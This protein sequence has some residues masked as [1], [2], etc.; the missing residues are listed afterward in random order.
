MCIHKLS[1]QDECFICFLSQTAKDG[2]KNEIHTKKQTIQLKKNGQRPEQTFFQRRHTDGQQ[3]RKRRSTSLIIR[4]MQI[5][6]TKR[7]H[8]T[9]VGM[10]SIRKMRYN[11]YQRGRVE[12]GTLLH[13][14][15][16][17]KLVQPLWKTV[18]KFFKNLKIGL[19]H[20]PAILFLGI[21][22]KK[23]KTLTQKDTCIPKLTEILLIITKIWKQL[24]CPSIYN[25]DTHTHTHIT[26]YYSAIKKKKQ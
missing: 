20:N 23:T 12:N 1:T 2:A 21:Y 17:C 16:E 9:S 11:K 3:H 6:F 15:G 10:A 8:L 22:L 18:W 25:K 24:K 7:H 26:E 19:P 13:Y 14:W 5:K 4:E